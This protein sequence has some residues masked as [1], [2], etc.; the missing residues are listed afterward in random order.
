[1][2]GRLVLAPRLPFPHCHRLIELHLNSM[3]CINYLAL[4]AMSAS[5]FQNR[6]PPLAG[7]RLCTMHCLTVRMPC[8]LTIHYFGPISL[9]PFLP[10]TNDALNGMIWSGF[11]S[12]N[13]GSLLVA[14]WLFVSGNLIC[15][16]AS[17]QR[18]L[19]VSRLS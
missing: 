15:I 10:H 5:C 19:D 16:R 3:L 2:H 6:A 12:D 8:V 1:M 4:C 11:E 18:S 13:F 17:S 9:F 7:T 14:I